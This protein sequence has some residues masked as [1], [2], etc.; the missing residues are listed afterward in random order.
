VLVPGESSARGPTAPWPGSRL[1]RLGE[2][3]LKVLLERSAIETERR[4]AAQLHMAGGSAQQE[5]RQRYGLSD[6]TP[7]RQMELSDQ[8]DPDEARPRHS[9]SHPTRSRPHV[10]DVVMRDQVV[11]PLGWCIDSKC[12]DGNAVSAH[13]IFLFTKE[14]TVRLGEYI[15]LRK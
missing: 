6:P 11:G 10:R 4:P 3:P 15:I 5:V 1:E 12:C 14:A 9:S 2:P 8:R 13:V 7:E